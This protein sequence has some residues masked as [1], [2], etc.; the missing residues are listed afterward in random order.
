MICLKINGYARQKTNVIESNELKVASDYI[1]SLIND[2]V[3]SIPNE[4]LLDAGDHNKK[5]GR[6]AAHP[7]IL[8]KTILYGYSRRQFSGRKIELIMQENL[9]MM[10]LVQ[11]QIFSHDQ[12][13][14]HQRKNGPVFETDFYPIYRKTS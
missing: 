12:F 1:V 3:N 9:P 8:L 10:W 5:T 6:P 13:L 11:Q 4:V 14:Y 7:G 2:F